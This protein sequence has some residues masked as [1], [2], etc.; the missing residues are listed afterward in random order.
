[1][2]HTNEN[3]AA[4]DDGARQEIQSG[5]IGPAVNSQTKTKVKHTAG[6]A[7]ASVDEDN[8]CLYLAIE[9]NN[10]CAVVLT[11]P[12]NTSETPYVAIWHE[13]YE[14]YFEEG[15]LDRE[16]RVWAE[17]AAGVINRETYFARVGACADCG[18]D[19]FS[20][21][22]YYMVKDHVWAQAQGG[23]KLLCIGCLE[24]RIG[25]TLT[26]SD[27]GDGASVNARANNS[28]ASFLIGCERV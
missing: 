1:M 12:K 26:R 15:L 22:E 18:V 14:Q 17:L 2:L 27:F 10:D 16:F 7:V 6:I 28:V 13:T 19:T 9:L 21:N 4:G 11:F 25:R 8:D 20:T 5:R 3:P 24:K 23:T